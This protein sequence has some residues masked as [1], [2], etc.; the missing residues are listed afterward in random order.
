VGN[1][2]IGQIVR[3]G[4]YYAQLVEGGERPVVV[5]SSDVVTNAL[6]KPVVC[7]LTSAERERSLPTAVRLPA[8]EAGLERDSYALCHE[9]RTVRAERLRREIGVLSGDRMAEIEAALRS[10]LDLGGA[11]PAAP[12]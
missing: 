7:E 10:T 5:V 12:S 6:R 2:L 9:L 3:G 4:I 1:A 11:L 8:G